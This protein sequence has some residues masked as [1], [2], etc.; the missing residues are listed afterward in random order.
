M[1]LMKRELKNIC[2]GV[3]MSANT[4]ITMLINF[5]FECEILKQ[6]IKPFITCDGQ[7]L[8]F[9][10]SQVTVKA[11]TTCLIDTKI[12]IN[13]KEE[14][15]NKDSKI[16]VDYIRLNF[17]LLFSIHEKILF[18]GLLYIHKQIVSFGN[19]DYFKISLVNHTNK[20]ITINKG[21]PLGQFVLVQN[22][23]SIRG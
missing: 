7:I 12:K 15:L 9:S 13:S 11:N 10:P 3:Q 20:D 4:L 21:E 18:N 14:I 22:F 17:V 23:M 2:N 1:E 5:D 19:R 16:D 6:T 8:I